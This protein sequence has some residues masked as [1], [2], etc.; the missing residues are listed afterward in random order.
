MSLS[1]LCEYIF[2]LEEGQVDV[3]VCVGCI[4][5]ISII[6]YFENKWNKEY[7]RDNP[8]RKKL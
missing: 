2:C 6:W 5:I 3:L 1:Q 8:T 7:E 4:I